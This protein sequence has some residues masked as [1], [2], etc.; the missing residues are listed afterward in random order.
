MKRKLIIE[1]PEE[2]AWALAQFLKRA[3]IDHYRVLAADQEEAQLMYEAAERAHVVH[4]LTW[5]T[6]RSIQFGWAQHLKL[7]KKFVPRIALTLNSLKRT[8]W[9]F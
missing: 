7:S 2:Q 6:A 1:L 9:S 5:Q 4:A 8:G 3:G